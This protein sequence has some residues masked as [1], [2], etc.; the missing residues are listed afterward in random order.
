MYEERLKE[1]GRN[2]TSLDSHLA[3]RIVRLVLKTLVPVSGLEHLECE[4][5][6]VK[7]PCGLLHPFPD[8]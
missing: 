5:H 4:V 2:V 3:V 1:V 7:A 6:V 8:I